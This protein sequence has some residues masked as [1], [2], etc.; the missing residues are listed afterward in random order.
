MLNVNSSGFDPGPNIQLQ[1][2]KLHQAA[3]VSGQR[4]SCYGAVMPALSTIGARR[5]RSLRIYAAKPSPLSALGSTPSAASLILTSGSW[6]IADR[7][8]IILVTMALSR[9]AGQIGRASCRE[10]VCLYV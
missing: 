5:S 7:S 1:A 4:L 3:D 6:P 10:R 8:A 9:L 2:P